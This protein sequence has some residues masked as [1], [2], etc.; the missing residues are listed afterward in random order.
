M[1]RPLK[2]LLQWKSA[3][4]VYLFLGLDPDPKLV[5]MPDIHHLEKPDPNFLQRLNRNE[6]L[7]IHKIQLTSQFHVHVVAY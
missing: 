3:C 7:R 5:E 2:L 4:N 6:K 1:K